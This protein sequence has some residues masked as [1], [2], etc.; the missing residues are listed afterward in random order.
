MTLLSMTRGDTAAFAI[1]LTDGAGDPLDLTGVDITFTAKR[2]LRDADTDAVFQKT[3]GAGIEVDA[4]PTTGL[5]TLSF[6][7]TDTS[8]LTDLRPLHWDIQVEGGGEVST[9]L[10]GRL[11]ISTDVTREVAGS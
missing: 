4:D 6:L 11:V 3:V 7:P 8:G 2:R 10:S 1:A 5:A 9:P